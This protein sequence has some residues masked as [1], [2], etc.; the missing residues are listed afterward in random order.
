[1]TKEQSYSDLP[2][3]SSMPISRSDQERDEQWDAVL[4]SLQSRPLSEVSTLLIDQ[5]LPVL[6]KQRII[7]LLLS[8]DYTTLNFPTGR[9]RLLPSYLNN[10]RD[11]IAT[12]P[13]D[14]ALYAAQLLPNYISQAQA[15]ATAGKVTAKQALD[16][17]SF[18]ISKLL[19][20]L[21]DQVATL[22]FTHYQILDREIYWD[23]E[24]M[25]GYNEVIHLFFDQSVPEKW[26]RAAAEQLHQIILA[27]A[28]GERTPRAEHEQALKWLQELLTL[29]ASGNFYSD[30]LFADQ[31]RFL[32][33]VVGDNQVVDGWS[34]QKVLAHLHEPDLRLRFVRQ[35][36]FGNVE[37]DIQRF[38][39][40]SA[41]EA[42]F[43]DKLRTEFAEEGDIIEYLDAQ[44]VAW[45]QSLATNS[46]SIK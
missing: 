32:L 43:A 42:A 28:N 31:V 46:E 17:Y 22:L 14:L 23:M 18:V 20:H 39:V 26:K 10:A 6:Y 44:L 41:D 2:G 25:S 4:V 7:Q 9:D 12:I 21:P 24:E 15:E 35:Q 1:M 27:E 37:F 34:T 16:R 3:L 33:S 29:T 19:V 5:E 36:L 13:T 38:T 45:Q 11:W 30:E 40:Y 8:P